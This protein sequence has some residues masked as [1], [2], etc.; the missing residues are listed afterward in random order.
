MI[1]NKKVILLILPLVFLFL[2]LSSLS[3]LAKIGVDSM[4]LSF[5]IS[6]G[7]SAEYNFR[8]YNSSDKEEKIIIRFKD[9]IRDLNGRTLLNDP[10]TLENSIIPYLE[11][12]PRSFTIPANSSQAVNIKVKIPKEVS[13]PHWGV[14]VIQTANT[15]KVNSESASDNSKRL[16]AE[17]STGLGILLTQSDPD[18]MESKG[19]VRQITSIKSTEGDKAGYK[20]SILY[21]NTG[22]I[23]QFGTGWFELTNQQGEKVGRVNIDRFF[24]L[25]GGDIILSAFFPK[26]L[27]AGK[28]LVLGVVDTGSQDLIAGQ[29]LL[30]V[31]ED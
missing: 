28:Y 3:T 9:C 12:V 13:G 26:E 2:V 29:Q 7:T 15:L 19:E 1:I 30:L 18:K 25:P 23:Y 4:Y 21:K 22:T 8:V 11:I 16:E 20:L 5:N 6:S 27:S 10:E 17:M 14:V 24:V 31:K